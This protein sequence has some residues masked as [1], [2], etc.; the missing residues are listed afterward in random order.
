MTRKSFGEI[1]EGDVPPSIIHYVRISLNGTVD[2]EDEYDGD[3]SEEFPTKNELQPL[4][5]NEVKEVIFQRV[6]AQG[7]QAQFFICR[8][9]G[10][11][12]ISFQEART[13]T[14]TPRIG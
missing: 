13:I 11:L 12:E 5:W 14:F 10:A 9:N 6:V 8:G 2:I 3:I 7:Y 1:N 4:V